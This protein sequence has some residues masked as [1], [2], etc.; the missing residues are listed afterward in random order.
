MHFFTRPEQ[1]SLS[2]AMRPIR[3]MCLIVGNDFGVFPRHI[4]DV[5]QHG[6]SALSAAVGV[7]AKYL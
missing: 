6:V 7:D 1:G 3:K 2:N 4:A 5:L